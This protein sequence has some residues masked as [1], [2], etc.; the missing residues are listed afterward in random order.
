M[1]RGGG[2]WGAVGAPELSPHTRLPPGVHAIVF[3]R[4][5]VRARHGRGCPLCRRGVFPGLG[6]AQVAMDPTGA[7]DDVPPLDVPAVPLQVPLLG[8][9][10]TCCVGRSE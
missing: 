4:V 2:G 9:Q 1:P 10:C 7:E 8:R 5:G 6:S 3:G